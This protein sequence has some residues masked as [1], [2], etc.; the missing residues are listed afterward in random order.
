MKLI[1]TLFI[2][3]MGNKD[4]PGKEINTNITKGFDNK[5]WGK[6]KHLN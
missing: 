1:L 3:L 5:N 4:S 6:L 2:P